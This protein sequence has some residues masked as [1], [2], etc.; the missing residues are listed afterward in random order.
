V[1]HHFRGVAGLQEAMAERVLRETREGLEALAQEYPSP[2]DRI[3][4]LARALL[5]QPP[6]A[7]A[8][9]RRV[10]RFWLDEG[11]AGAARDA[12]VTDFIE[13]TLKLGRFRV[14]GRELA[15]MV[16]ARWHGATAVYANGGTVDFERETERLVAQIDGMLR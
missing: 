4:A 10:Q 2:R 15:G 3:E 9:T 7:P 14:D 1:F 12:L 6:D 13:K 16:L 5:S 8:P 11:G